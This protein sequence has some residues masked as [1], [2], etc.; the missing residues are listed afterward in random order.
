MLRWKIN[1]VTIASSSQGVPQEPMY[2]ILSSGL[3]KE[4]KGNN[5]PASM[6]VD[7]VR[8]YKRK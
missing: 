8:C 6:E 5:L 3:Y 4:I 1:G 2:L 7:W